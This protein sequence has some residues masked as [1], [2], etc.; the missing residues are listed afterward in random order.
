MVLNKINV[1]GFLL[2]ISLIASAQDQGTKEKSKKINK[3][4]QWETIVKDF[5][6]VKLKRKLPK[7][8]KALEVG[9]GDSPLCSNCFYLD[10]GFYLTDSAQIKR[11]V[12]ADAQ[13]M[14]IKDKS[15]DVIIIKNFPWYLTYSGNSNEELR[16]QL[17]RINA[18]RKLNNLEPLTI[19]VY[20]NIHE[21][22][23]RLRELVMK[24]IVRIASSEAI[25]FVFSNMPAETDYFHSK[26]N[27][28][29]SDFGFSPVK[30]KLLQEY[31]FDKQRYVPVG[32]F[33][34]LKSRKQAQ[35]ISCVRKISNLMQN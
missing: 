31:H 35:L 13:R 29:M 33:A 8:L 22:Q 2:V 18:H 11:A 14:P 1:L 32:G 10:Y 27:E 20:T 21:D 25:I 26:F 16:V 30:T 12:V 24:E 7:D 4:I 19:E 9:P 23:V 6:S 5:L 28:H 17:D 3:A 15:I 34:Y